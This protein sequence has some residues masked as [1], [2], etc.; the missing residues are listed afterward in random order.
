[1]T[2]TGRPAGVHLRHARF[3]SPRPFRWRRLHPL[4]GV[5]LRI[6]HCR[7]RSQSSRGG[8]PQSNAGLSRL[9]SALR[10]LTTSASGASVGTSWSNLRNCSPISPPCRLASK[11][12]PTS[13]R[14]RWP[15]PSPASRCLSA[16]TGGSARAATR[17]PCRLIARAEMDLP[18][19]RSSPA[20][21]MTRCCPMWALSAVAWAVRRG[22]AS[23]SPATISRLRLRLA[24]WDR[25]CMPWSRLKVP[26]GFISTAPKQC[27]LG[28]CETSRK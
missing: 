10:W 28:S 14:A 4:R 6:H 19:S 7:Q 17:W 23:P 13:G 20:T 18:G 27:R 15:V 25:C 12:S 16:L 22:R 21:T 8:Y 26:G 5:A 2:L 3:D 11:A 1:M 9:V 24:A